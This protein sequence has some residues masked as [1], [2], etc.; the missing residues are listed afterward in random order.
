MAMSKRILNGQRVS[1]RTYPDAGVGSLYDG[2]ILAFVPAGKALAEMRSQTPF[3]KDSDRWLGILSKMEAIKN[4]AFRLLIGALAFDFDTPVIKTM[5]LRLDVRLSSGDVAAVVAARPPSF[6]LLMDAIDALVDEAIWHAPPEMLS[7][8]K[9][10]V[11]G[12]AVGDAKE[13]TP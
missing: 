13:G 4:P 3:H 2:T 12:C 7:E 1:W 5:G 6:A 11:N 10:T 9:A 8:G